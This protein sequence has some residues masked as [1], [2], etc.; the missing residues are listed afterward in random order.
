MSAGLLKDGDPIYLVKWE[1]DWPLPRLLHIQSIADVELFGI[2][3][4]NYGEF[5]IEKDEWERRFGISA[6][7]LQ[8][9]T[10]PST[11]A[12]GTVTPTPSPVSTPEPSPASDRAALVALY[13]ATGGANWGTTGA[14]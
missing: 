8:R 2:N 10:L 3:S 4:S 14:G 5:V 6:A 11:S 9:G 13:N 7:G 1:T 12:P